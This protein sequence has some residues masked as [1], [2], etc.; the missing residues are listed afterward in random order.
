MTS[1]D[2]ICGEKNGSRQKYYPTYTSAM[3]CGDRQVISECGVRHGFS[4]SPMFG[5][6]TYGCKNRLAFIFYG[7]TTGA[8]PLLIMTKAICTILRL[9]SQN[10]QN[11]RFGIENHPKKLCRTK[12][13]S[14]G[15]LDQ[16][17]CPP[18]TQARGIALERR[19]SPATTLPSS[20]SRN[21]GLRI[22]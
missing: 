10:G 18:Q 11:C 12:V 2:S 3:I 19:N 15:K 13:T 17:G 1:N 20:P 21:L 5:G 8:N 9:G 22:Q 14:K 7:N 16:R 4:L 6:M